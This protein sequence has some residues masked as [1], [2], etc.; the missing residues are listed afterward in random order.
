M[1]I[2][3]PNVAAFCLALIAVVLALRHRAAIRRFLGSMGHLGPGNPGDERMV[4]F[5]AFAVV[6]VTAVVIVKRLTRKD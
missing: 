2:I 3:W 6:A 1:K 4:G 5:I